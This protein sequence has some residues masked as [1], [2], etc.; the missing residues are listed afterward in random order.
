[1]PHTALH[2]RYFHPCV[3]PPGLRYPQPRGKQQVGSPYE[4]LSRS[5]GRETASALITPRWQ[6][7]PFETQT[8]LSVMSDPL[9]YAMP[10][11]DSAPF[12]AT[13]HPLS[14]FRI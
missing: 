7:I 5:E 10:Q 1:M 12:T 11:V 8:R 14:S 6:M 4:S 9:A 13:A 2:R 3:H